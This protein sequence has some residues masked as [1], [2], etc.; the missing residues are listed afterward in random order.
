MKK[1]AIVG[2]G[3]H[4]KVVAEIAQLNGWTSL[5]FFDD[6]WPTL[7]Q[8]SDYTVVGNI[9]SLYKSIVDYDGVIIAIGNNEIRAKLYLTLVAQ[10]ANFISLIHPRAIISTRTKIGNGT[11]IMANVVINPDVVIGSNCIINSSS[12]I[13]HDCFINDHVHICPNTALAGE[14][15]VDKKAWIGIGS[16][17]I[18]QINIGENVFVGA[19]STVIHDIPNELKVVGTPAREI[20]NN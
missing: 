2:A 7:T 8:F 6:R 15:K 5:D 16:T 18:Q 3:G 4:S 17:V 19:G 14:V 20:T 11:V 1:L 9:Q 12:V 10:D 13:E